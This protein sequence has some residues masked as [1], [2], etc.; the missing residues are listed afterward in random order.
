[1]VSPTEVAQAASGRGNK[2][3][4]T[5]IFGDAAA[6][7]N[8][9]TIITVNDSLNISFTI[10]VDGGTVAPGRYWFNG[11][12]QSG[13]GNF[14]SSTT[15]NFRANFTS[16]I[17]SATVNF[18]F[19]ANT[20]AGDEE[21]NR[22]IRIIFD[23]TT[24]SLSI[25]PFANAIDSG[26]NSGY[27]FRLASNGSLNIQ[28][29]DNLS[30][31]SFIKVMNGLT[32]ITSS[33][34]S[35]L[36]LAGSA[37]PAGTSVSWD[38]KCQDIAGN[39]IERTIN[40]SNDNIVPEITQTLSSSIPANGCIP[41][42]WS[43]WTSSSDLSSP[44]SIFVSLDNGVTWS[45]H[46]NPFSPG[47]NFSGKISY[48][49][50]DAVGLL[51]YTNTTNVT[52]DSFAP[53]ITAAW[54]SSNQTFSVSVIDQCDPSP[55]LTARWESSNGSFS[56]W[57][58]P[59]TTQS[60][61]IP[62]PYNTTSS[63]LH[64]RSQDLAGRISQ[65][66]S[67]WIA[68]SSSNSEPVAYVLNSTSLS[69]YADKDIHFWI[70]VPSSVEMTMSVIV[71]GTL[72]HSNTS[73]SDF[74]ADYL[75]SDGQVIQFQLQWDDDGINGSHY[76]NY[77]IDD[78]VGVYPSISING[79]SV[80]DISDLFISG[81]SS[82][83][84][85][86]VSDDAGGVGA[87]YCECRNGTI[88]AFSR[89]VGN[90]FSLTA[91]A[92][93]EVWYNV[94]CRT[95]DL[96]GNIGSKVWSNG[97]LDSIAPTVSVS[98][99]GNPIV[100]PVSTIS[101]L[102]SDSQG[103]GVSRT[104]WQ[105]TDGADTTY[106]YEN[107]STT[108]WSGS[109]STIFS[110]N[111]SDG[112][113]SLTI[114]AYDAL[115]NLNT[116]S[117]HSFVVNSSQSGASLTISGTKVM[118]YLLP[119][120]ATFYL[121]P[122]SGSSL[123]N[124]NWQMQMSD[125]EIFASGN[126]T[127]TV[128]Q[129]LSN[130]EEGPF[131]VNVTTTDSQG[132]SIFQSWNYSIDGTVE[133]NAT[134]SFIGTS[135]L[136]TTTSMTFLSTGSAVSLSN[137]SD[138]QDGVGYSYS[139][140]SQSGSSWTRTTASSFSISSVANQETT[141]NIECRIVDLLGNKGA[142]QWVNG[143]IDD[144]N[145]VV[146]VEPTGNAKIALNS[147]IFVNLSDSQGLATSI[148]R[149]SWNNGS[150]NDYYNLTF[151][152]KYWNGTAKSL[153]GSIGDGDISLT[154]YAYDNLSNLAT[155]TGHQWVL[156]NTLAQ[157]TIS[158]SGTNVNS[159]LPAT[160]SSIHITPPSGWHVALSMDWSIEMSG[161][162][163]ASGSAATSAI[164]QALN[165]LEDGRLWVNVTMTDVY[166]RSVSTS[167]LY[168]VDGNVS[169]QPVISI[170]GTWI[171]LSGSIFLSA[172]ASII[173]SNLSDDASGVGYSYSECK[174]ASQSTWT[175][176]TGAT[177][178]PNAAIDQETEINI[179]CRIVD[180]LGNRG[181][182]IW[183]N[184][185]VDA[186]KPSAT[187]EPLGN[188]KIARNSTIWVNLNDT[189]GLSTSHLRFTWT[190]GSTT[191]YVNRTFS[192]AF[193]NGTPWGLFGSQGDG[194]ISLTLLAYDNLGNL[195]QTT[196]YQ[197]VL[198]TTRALATI[199]V[200]GTHVNSY[201]PA[202]GTTIYINP[203]S[204][205]HVAVVMN[206]S[207]ERAG[208]I[209]FAN[210][211]SN[212]A[213]ISQ[214]LDDMTDGRLWVNVTT[215]DAYGRVVNQSRLFTID[216]NITG[217]PVL[218]ISG[219]SVTI[220][221]SLY[222][223]ADAAI[224]L[225]NLSDDATGVGFSHAQ[226]KETSSS[227]WIR[228]TGTSFAL[229][230]TPSQEVSFEIECRLVDLL[231][232]TGTSVIINGTIDAIK[233]SVS[234]TPTGNPK[235]ALETYLL[236]NL[237]DSQGLGTSVLRF[238]WQNGS[239]SSTRELN[240]SGANWNSSI[241]NIFGSIGDG[242][243]TLVVDAY[244]ALGNLR[245]SAGHSWV[246]NTTLPLSS[247]SISGNQWNEYLPADGVSISFNPPSG[248]HLAAVMNWT[249]VLQNGTTYA[250]GTNNTS[251][252]VTL[253][254]ISD[255]YLW[256]NITTSDAFG[257]TV[258]QTWN[259][260]IDG[261][262]GT[263][264]ILIISGSSLTKNSTLFVAASAYVSVSNLSDD[265]W[266]VGYSHVLCKE[267]QSLTWTQVYSSFDLIAVSGQETEFNVSCR[268]V[269][270]FSNLGEIIWIN[271]SIDAL[272]PEVIVKPSGNPTIA[273]ST[274]LYVNLSDS[275][276]LSTSILNFSWS[277]GSSTV[278]RQ[279][280]FSGS[281]WNASVLSLFGSL[282]DGQ[283]VLTVYAYDYLGNLNTSTGHQW[284][285]NTTLPQATLSF[286]G[287]SF[288]DYI[289]ANNVTIYLSPPSG[290]HLAA[291]INWT[292]ELEDGSE[293]AN[294]S[295]NS[296]IS[297][298]L[299]NVSD[300]YLWVNVSVM[301]AY[302]REVSKSWRFR[303]DGS[304]YTKP[305]M[306]ITGSLVVLENIAYVSANS[307]ITLSNMRDDAWGVGYDFTEC[308][309]GSS[310]SWSTVFGGNF[311]LSAI[312]DEEVDFNVT[313]RIVDLFGNRGDT[314]WLSGSIDALA[315]S[316][317][318]FPGANPTIAANSTLRVDISDARGIGTTTLAWKWTDG[319]T[320]SWVN[321]TFTS[322][323]WNGTSISIF[324]QLS[325]GVIS[326]S[327]SSYDLLGNLNNSSGYQWNLNN[328]LPQPTLS[329]NGTLL[330]GYLP[331]NNVSLIISPP[332]GA[333]LAAI[334]NWTIEI[335]GFGEYTNGSNNSS[336][337]VELNNLTD[338]R[339]WVNVTVIDTFGRSVLQIWQYTVD[340]NV[341]LLP[342][343]TYSGQ[344]S[345]L[346]NSTW[347]SASTTVLLANLNDDSNGVGFDFVECSNASNGT[348]SALSSSILSLTSIP[349]N[350]TNFSL[351]CRIV[352][353]LGNRGGLANI[354]GVIDDIQ[355]TVGVQYTSGNVLSVN[356]TIDFSCSDSLYSSRF[357]L[358][359]YHSNNTN[360]SQGNISLAD[361]NPTLSSLG[362]LPTGQLHL[363]YSCRDDVGNIGTFNLSGLYYTVQS[364]ASDISLNGLYSGQYHSN[365]TTMSYSIISNGHLNSSIR[366][367]VVDPNINHL[368]WDFNSTS[369]GSIDF[370]NLSSGLYIIYAITCSDL[371][372]TSNNKQIRIDGDGPV[373]SA[374][375]I[376]QHGTVY[377][378]S[379]NISVGKD[380]RLR[381]T[382]LND[383]RSG[384]SE[385]HCNWTGNNLLINLSNINWWQPWFW[386]S[387][388]DGKQASMSCKAYDNLGNVGPVKVWNLS[389]DFTP[390]SI[391]LSVDDD[392]G[393]IYPDT[394]VQYNCSDGNYSTTT[395]ILWS[396]STGSNL[397][398]DVNDAWNGNISTILPSNLSDGMS[399]NLLIICRDQ[400]D[401]RAYSNNLS[402]VYISGF[403][404]PSLTYS[405]TIDNSSSTVLGND[406]TIL[407]IPSPALGR[408]N[409]TAHWNNG[410]LNWSI[411][412]NTPTS[413]LLNST[414][415][416]AI[417]NDSSVPSSVIFK[418]IHYSNETN[419]TAKI[420][421]G[422][423]TQM[424]SAPGVA[425]INRSILADGIS[426]NIQF[427]A[428]I[429]PWINVDM[430]LAGA[431]S[432]WNLS[433]DTFD[434]SMPVGSAGYEILNLSIRDCLGNFAME[435]INLTR[436][437][438][439]P[440]F[441]I[442]GLVSGGTSSTNTL[443]LN[444]SD[445]TGFESIYFSLWFNNSTTVLC[446]GVSSCSFTLSSYINSSH[447]DS[448]RI[449]INGL[450]NS[451]QRLVVNTSFTI[452]DLLIGLTLDQNASSNLY[453]NNVSNASTIVFS[454]G[455]NAASICLSLDNDTSPLL[456]NYNSSSLSYQPSH[457]ISGYHDLTVTAIDSHGNSASYFLNYSHRTTSPL[458]TK[459]FH[460]MSGIAF[461]NLNINHPIPF[462]V[463][464]SNSTF[465]SFT[466]ESTILF[467]GNGSGWMLFNL[468]IVDA[469]GLNRSQQ[470]V[471]VIDS[472][473]PLIAFNYSGPLSLG[474]NTNFTLTM[475]EDLVNISSFSIYVDDGLNNCTSPAP[476]SLNNSFYVTHI[477]TLSQII[478]DPTCAIDGNLTQTLS[479]WIIV[480]NAV[481]L[482]SFIPRNITYV[483]GVE[484]AQ[485]LLFNALQVGNVVYVSNLSVII[486]DYSA[487][488]VSV[489][490]TAQT[491]INNSN[492]SLN[493]LTS[494]EENGILYCVGTDIFNNS[495]NTSFTIKFIAD[496]LV[497]N[498]DYLNYSSGINISKAGVGNI[499]LY[500]SQNANL[501]ISWFNY[502]VDGIENISSTNPHLIISNLSAGNHSINYYAVS[503]LG[504]RVN[505]SFNITI[506]DDDPEYSIIDNSYIEVIVI[507]LLIYKRY[508]TSTRLELSVWDNTCQV[509]P[510]VLFN[511]NSGQLIN[512]NLVWIV[513]VG[514][515]SINIT[516]TDCVGHTI[517]NQYTL[518]TRYS[519]APVNSTID[520]PSI[521]S[522][523]KLQIISKNNFWFNVS[524]NDIIS[525][526]LSC[527]DVS[528]G[529]DVS[530]ERT[531]DSNTSWRLN[532]SD[533]NTSI[534][535][536]SI[537]LR[538]LDGVGVERW[539][540]ITVTWDDV[541][542]SCV[543]EGHNT[544]WLL[545]DL[546]VVNVEC[547]DALSN[548]TYLVFVSNTG[549]ILNK[550]SNNANFDLSSG[551]SSW[552]LYAND[553]FGN[554]F[555][556]TITLSTD[557]SA[558]VISCSANGV[559]ILGLDIYNSSIAIECVISDSSQFHTDYSIQLENI[560]GYLDSRTMLSA[561]LIQI[562]LNSNLY[563]GQIYN[564][565]VISYD[566]FGQASP[567]TI[568]RIHIDRLSPMLTLSSQS[569]YGYNFG[570]NRVDSE[571]EFTVSFYD[572]YQ[573]S[574]VETKLECVGLAAKIQTVESVD[575]NHQI[576]LD[577]NYIQSCQSDDIALSIIAKDVAM[578]INS[579]IQNWILRIDSTPPTI[580]ISMTDVCD[581]RSEDSVHFMRSSC[582]VSVRAID[583]D[584]RNGDV[585]I[586]V[587][588]N[589]GSQYWQGISIVNI[590]MFLF[591]DLGWTL[592]S[593]TA[594][595]LSGK[596]RTFSIAIQVVDELY[597]TFS[598]ETCEEAIFAIC[599]SLDRI[600]NMSEHGV[601]DFR[602][603]E[604]EVDKTILE[605]LF[606]V[607]YCDSEN[608]CHHETKI[609]QFNTSSLGKDSL[610]L[611]DGVY[612][613][614]VHHVDE[615]GR[616]ANIT[617][618]LMLDIQEPEIFIDISSS[619]GYLDEET[620][621]NCAEDCQL[622]FLVDEASIASV[623]V[624]NINNSIENELIP[625]E[626]FFEMN[627]SSK[628][629]VPIPMPM[630]QLKIVVTS[631]TGRQVNKT[632]NVSS[633]VNV[634]SNSSVIL[635]IDN[636]ECD[637]GS[638]IEYR[639]S[640]FAG[641]KVCFFDYNS[642]D[643]GLINL[644]I[645]W[646]RP[647]AVNRT[648]EVGHA[649]DSTIIANEKWVVV[650]LSELVNGYTIQLEV[651]NQLGIVASEA[652]IN[653]SIII[654]DPYNKDL[655]INISL[656][657][658][659][660]FTVELEWET[661]ELQFTERGKFV[662]D[663]TVQISPSSKQ[664]ILFQANMTI[665]NG[666]K[667]DL[668][669]T[670]MCTL[671]GKRMEIL[672]ETGFSGEIF[673][674]SWNCTFSVSVNQNG[675]M[676]INLTKESQPEFTH[677]GR[678]D[679][680]LFMADLYSFSIEY[681]DGSGNN[682]EQIYASNDI[683]FREEP[684]VTPIFSSSSCE[685]DIKIYST[686][687]HDFIEE[688]VDWDEL[689][690]CLEGIIDQDISQEVGIRF[691]LIVVAGSDPIVINLLCKKNNLIPDN[692]AD[693]IVRVTNGDEDCRERDSDN[694]D[695]LKLDR[696]F[697]EIEMRIISCDLRC[698]NDQGEI[699][700]ISPLK[701]SIEDLDNTISNPDIFVEAVL[702]FGLLL[703]AGV[704][705]KFSPVILHR[706]RLLGILKSKKK[707]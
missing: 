335:E 547:H 39:L 564:V 36:L 684:D 476:Y 620:L 137:L 681:T 520:Q 257:R 336:V 96:L 664:S 676:T 349:N 492:T 680:P 151:F 121:N 322:T 81:T 330:N 146:L 6:Q 178:N 377:N 610:P 86:N 701:Y 543:I 601:I 22:T 431:N 378:G 28:C 443:L 201:L 562:T 338:G 325:D 628:F 298:E 278:W 65:W 470:I 315:P 262:V 529:T 109:L 485:L 629:R 532:V 465:G 228:T 414:H 243:I 682:H 82:L 624:F 458:A 168:S 570:S 605:E 596:V 490:V 575:F 297:Q 655:T 603:V 581:Y 75:F 588:V 398:N 672:G 54:V 118:N 486:C 287:Q 651:K 100:A 506:D 55:S 375:F 393:Y 652:W 376:T 683:E 136:N 210:G 702:G 531:G 252:S 312:A 522:G 677:S 58:I 407:I 240:F 435:S 181:S 571:G 395:D 219:T 474:P 416:N 71:D 334:I 214:S 95:I 276:N 139:E 98:P 34:G 16:I 332:S 114:Y 317:S 630:D 2:P 348:F 320:T 215:T 295:G 421:I 678:K 604:V 253:D 180:L 706:L 563:H 586:N 460:E 261:S 283:I 264:P 197:W 437:L 544:S 169:S 304:V 619:K 481:G 703:G 13:S 294:G 510:T 241:Q 182:S 42:T 495:M 116:S 404:T 355:P 436:D 346:N 59:S 362:L 580:I 153:F 650:S 515:S 591:K 213:T 561:G 657:D 167:R 69:G 415:F 526:N 9:G 449:L 514:V 166:G 208:N 145:P 452:D 8:G 523:N 513:P 277:D 446:S 635:K 230:S 501:T 337:E 602:L 43:V 540:N 536:S 316:I 598:Y 249:I 450:T 52:V 51:N 518:I 27:D 239:A 634:L 695:K 218:S 439:P 282:G 271:G 131:W 87:S 124:L 254:A 293:F 31:I 360:I 671:N 645:E 60:F 608:A 654:K 184:A 280:N 198:N 112:D 626:E 341:G 172:N 623:R 496:D 326:L 697:A 352:D 665:F 255:G 558:P 199:S 611:D 63:M 599:N 162:T 46:S 387:S 321:G 143:T 204:G 108:S 289:A 477:S 38:V 584:S 459:L 391:S 546:T 503:V 499:R 123:S 617:F 607:T 232:N 388:L 279:H 323:T 693:W 392:F 306:T 637:S 117:G 234:V 45:S 310:D 579:S 29:T 426:A 420:T 19:R 390:P 451:G 461:I 511:N 606:D 157:A 480:S 188:P 447:G 49:A 305:N 386:N 687:N 456:C 227:T 115:G 194:D 396:Y 5:L 207:I 93:Q 164:T 653:H 674:F 89:V 365:N 370:T 494:I 472:S 441:T 560:T 242:N 212:N 142:S 500:S 440:Q 643:G 595:D 133:Q 302:G 530:C 300:G 56:A 307:I 644:T 102:L 20:T 345:S 542:P 94:S 497:T 704:L 593:I 314:Q 4:T 587:S 226:C 640:D 517:V 99:S 248:I 273:L 127:T 284:N 269:D 187:I 627:N 469:T 183:F 177:F 621:A 528:P 328:T 156:N 110:S 50:S 76:W 457:N 221:T 147:S 384:L 217:L 79:I 403:A 196:G 442:G 594:T 195:Y 125:G 641:D 103:V 192:G 550:T 468:S 185:T 462:T 25:S 556:Q 256:L 200:S 509:Q 41:H 190:D 559:A 467:I 274:I 592:L 622:V 359:W 161:N 632:F 216:G 698:I 600:I 88:D 428:N 545:D 85:S 266:G 534:S 132:R 463:D 17:T 438:S 639:D 647:N 565:S 408:L 358:S 691:T 165:G 418:I 275:Q 244:D 347:I 344:I 176:A 612:T 694:I 425:T 582:S 399:L 356:S 505:K 7:D 445:D 224:S 222:V 62:S 291:T 26:S 296:T 70:G 573:L 18:S 427:D 649:M 493:R 309:N 383:N 512:Q 549:T 585:I 152:G 15:L 163:I 516:V 206:W 281:S 179:E 3:V 464:I 660:M 488:F 92:G 263:T 128:T 615:M 466:S 424:L 557:N 666:Q 1:M 574:S 489:S 690:I 397:L 313:C 625:N 267:N 636:T 66:N 97:T 686:V 324:G 567:N 83:S 699:D 566:I 578:N 101:I 148:L 405:N 473:A 524:I 105:W 209:V 47:L 535:Q 270:R 638:K 583:N 552:T 135:W 521:V 353:L 670:G 203:P 340:G 331:A 68:A 527:T 658:R 113:V 491:D 268:I 502:S 301:D 368:Y 318:V 385:L 646:P 247:V 382:S 631:S 191:I 288:N 371:T 21:D 339:L 538:F 412:I 111:I 508:D 419:T 455:E 223:A 154:V 705:L 366:I 73:T 433:N 400:V 272:N 688:A 475:Q 692:L 285:L 569:K 422:P 661:S 229:T 202:S 231:G 373:G 155:S 351:F 669:E 707:V 361:Q 483:G 367:R 57:F 354:T 590:P 548:V 656:V 555:S 343:F 225:A 80:G 130:V 381:M 189:Q 260:T 33:S 61:A 149:F 700:E 160:G 237:G 104:V 668:E 613:L 372:C 507:D 106:A 453:L 482:S 597:F 541:M 471:V 245:Q 251:V 551:G 369:N 126:S 389:F 140:C 327:V 429:C 44:T 364:P 618:T 258:N 292:I 40:L 48:R 24:P 539:H 454:V 236:V 374:L 577:K 662:F 158:V 696:R 319:L 233:P 614:Y 667:T 174:D 205:W 250:S 150:A 84:I 246:L 129:T 401:N 259:Y 35:S 504:Y 91:V 171:N 411:D 159:Y 211:S 487:H 134:L 12:Q 576:I 67:T 609:S 238:Q 333:H 11:S 286:S 193:W 406:S 663:A 23:K 170:S 402:L 363:I 138:D 430:S 444:S 173:L 525:I 308:R 413:L 90:S 144:I 673:P 478:D 329:V 186:K 432:S 122:P 37:I 410:T 685:K 498:H 434:F 290:A 554:S 568:I 479:V 379:S 423:F 77:T 484:A 533:L 119:S 175:T 265:V 32:Q 311:S 107:F 679:L 120:G 659:K 448:G 141:F 537:N 409:I 30:N 357:G 72:T 342:T 616:Y 53:N 519:L 78:K 303:V 235:V 74:E 675:L 14:T 64:L 394:S 380:L 633:P 648:F 220:N 553:T 642:N 589:N 299:S 10:T 417:F 350:E 689:K 572:E